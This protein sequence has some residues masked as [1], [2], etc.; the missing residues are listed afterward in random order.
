M[1]C[2]IDPIKQSWRCIQAGVAVQMR[3][4]K[5]ALSTRVV[6]RRARVGAT[7]F[8]WEI[9]KDSMAEPVYVS[10]EAFASMEAAFQAGHARLA[11][12]TPPQRPKPD[13]TGPLF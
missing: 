6:V 8:V 13:P 3:L 12:F 9:N 7:P 4:S 1:C 5:E 10:P 2:Q 11:E